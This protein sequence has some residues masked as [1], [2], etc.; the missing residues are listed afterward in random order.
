MRSTAAAHSRVVNSRLSIHN[1][2]RHEALQFT[3]SGLLLA[4]VYGAGLSAVSVWF[5]GAEWDARQ[6]LGVYGVCMGLALALFFVWRGRLRPVAYLLVAPPI[7]VC[8]VSAASL[9]SVHYR[10]LLPMPTVTSVTHPP[11]APPPVLT[12]PVT[13][14]TR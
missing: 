7:F 3:L 2:Q 12:T 6:K 14:G 4:I 1:S 9:F 5:A 13:G 10:P 8:A 11:V